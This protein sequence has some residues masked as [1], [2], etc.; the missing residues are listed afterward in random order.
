MSSYSCPRSISVLL[1]KQETA[2][3]ERQ[4]DALNGWAIL[5]QFGWLATAVVLA[6]LVWQTIAFEPQLPRIVS[7]V[8]LALIGVLAGLRIGADSSTAYIVDLQR[9]NRVLAQQQRD[10]EE[11]NQMLL[12]QVGESRRIV[13]ESPASSKGV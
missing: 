12:M 6:L 13:S 2:A 9:T 11:L 3:D 7:A 4:G 8:L 10:L 5:K 1:P